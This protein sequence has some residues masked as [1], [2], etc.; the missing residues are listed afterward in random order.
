MIPTIRLLGLEFADLDVEHAAGWLARR[1]AAAPFGY[2]ATPNADHLVRLRRF[3]ELV[4]VYQGALMRLLDSRVVARV[5]RLAGLAVPRVAT[6]SDLTAMLLACHLAA[7]ERI[8]IVGLRPQWLPA[9]VAR[10]GIAPPAHFDPPTGFERE[11]ASL[12]AAVDFVLA[13]PA[14]FVFLAVG[15]PRQEILAAAIAATR[16]ATGVGLCIGASLE[17]LAGAARRAPVSNGC[18]GWATTR[19]RWRDVICATARR[20]FQCCCASV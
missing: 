1:P 20:C 16:Q 17:F 2:V 13:N 3:P 9:L 6:G 18:T 14:R 19:A 8:T 11:P 7:G 12:R 4:P 5:A 15:S 10:C